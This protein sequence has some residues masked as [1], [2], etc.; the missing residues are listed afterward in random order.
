MTWIRIDARVH[1]HPKVVQLAPQARWA[2]IVT[3]CEAK[4]VDG[5]WSSAAH[6]RACVGADGKHLK[7]LLDVG[8]LE[9]RGDAV[10]VHDWN[11]YQRALSDSTAAERMRRYRASKGEN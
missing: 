3:L 6:Y 7:A 8:L 10:V 4:A 11:D 2:W 5:A 1:K 9:L